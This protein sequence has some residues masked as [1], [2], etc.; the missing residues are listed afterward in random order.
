MNVARKSGV[1]AGIAQ[2]PDVE[3]IPLVELVLLWI[4]FLT[5]SWSLAVGAGW[6][7]LHILMTVFRFF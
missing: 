2:E 6:C 5:L 3:P 1:I 7:L 4:V